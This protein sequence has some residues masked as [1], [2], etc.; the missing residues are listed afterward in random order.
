MPELTEEQIETVKQL[1]QR[2]SLLEEKVLPKLEGQLNSVNEITTNLL[3]RIHPLEVNTPSII[4]TCQKQVS[5]LG[6]EIHTY[7]YC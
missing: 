4:S 1:L 3:H 7:I 6:A 5:D 2:V